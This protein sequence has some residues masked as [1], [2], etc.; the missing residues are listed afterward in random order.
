MVTL[1]M[2][3]QGHPLKKVRKPEAGLGDTQC[4]WIIN[5][6]TQVFGYHSYKVIP[7][8]TLMVT[9]QGH[10]P[11]RVR[12]A[13][14]GLVDTQWS[15]II[16]IITQVFG[17]HSYKVIPMVTLT[18]TFQG[19]PPKRV[20]KPEA[21][22]GDTQCVMHVPVYHRMSGVRFVAWWRVCT[23]LPW[24]IY[25][26]STWRFSSSIMSRPIGLFIIMSNEDTLHVSVGFK[27]FCI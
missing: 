21:G 6:I 23:S 3:F 9:F 7:M 19:H 22:L 5:I 17:Y 4:S 2:T 12:K 24:C 13:E 8:V 25:K 18:M 14:A 26:R 27:M 11:K 15:W 16:N 1:T 20:R 10:P